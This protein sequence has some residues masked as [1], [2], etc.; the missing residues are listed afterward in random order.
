M[1]PGRPIYPPI[2]E[3]DQRLDLVLHLPQVRGMLLAAREQTAE[4]VDERFPKRFEC[5]LRRRL[6]PEVPLRLHHRLLPH[7]FEHRRL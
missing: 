3:L 1:V 7:L 4:L 5:E 6:M 2:N